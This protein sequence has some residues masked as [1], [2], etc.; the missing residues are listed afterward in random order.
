MTAALDSLPHRPDG[1]PRLDLDLASPGIVRVLEGGSGRA[2]PGLPWEPKQ[3][4]TAVA[5]S[6]RG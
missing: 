3:A 4:F 5:E 2:Y 6:Y 1:D